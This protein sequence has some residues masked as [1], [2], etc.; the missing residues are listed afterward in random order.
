MSEDRNEQET[1]AKKSVSKKSQLQVLVADDERS[2]REIMGMM[3]NQQGH[4][5]KFA[6]NGEKALHM[7]GSIDFDL[8]ISDQNMPFL[9]GS[10]LAEAIEPRG[11]PFILITGTEA[12]VDEDCPGVSKV[13]SKPVSWECLE[14]AIGK[15]LKSA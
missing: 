11:I 6:E 1:A 12:C 7:V 4:H 3:L 10:E 9:K 5:V 2:I 14:A 15:V 8:I 13:L